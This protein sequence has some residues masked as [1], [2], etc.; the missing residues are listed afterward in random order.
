MTTHWT[1]STIPQPQ[2][3]AAFEA[4]EQAQRIVLITHFKPDGDAIGSLLGLA[5]ALREPGKNVIAVVDEGVPPYLRFNPGSDTV[6]SKLT[7][8]E[9]DVFVS[10]DSSDEERTGEAGI[11]A[12]AHSKLVINV[13]HHPTNT[14]F[15]QIY[16]VVPS[17]VSTTEI[18]YDWLNQVGLPITQNVAIPL[19]TGL[20]TDTMGFRINSVNERTL[21]IASALMHA[22]A[23]LND[24]MARTLGSMSWKSL[25]LW[26]LA[27]PTVQIANRVVS[28]DITQEMLKSAGL[29]QSTD[30]AG[31]I[32]FMNSVDESRVAVIFREIPDGKIEL[33]FRAKP[34]YDVATVALSLGGGGH[35][36]ASGATISGTLEE[37]KAKVLPLLYTIA[38]AEPQ[39]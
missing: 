9:F 32:S 8:G 18:V 19:L 36:L 33:G 5:N 22:G 14:G 3:Q 26:K 12:R 4:L 29:G 31:L 34:G 1:P 13:D 30:T 21:Q 2:Y 25:Q 37:V 35:R 16:V 17:A 27:L 6:L 11:Y 23:P 39:L 15:G 24:I 20:V 10:L 38:L 28:A 7:T